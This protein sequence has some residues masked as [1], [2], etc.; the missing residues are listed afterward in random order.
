MGVQ[1]DA[2][3]LAVLVTSVMNVLSQKLHECK[4]YFQ[5]C[6][7]ISVLCMFNYEFTL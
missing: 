3:E 2:K 7:R 5:V 1:C 6:M 4:V